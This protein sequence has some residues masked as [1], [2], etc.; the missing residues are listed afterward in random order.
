MTLVNM[1]ASRD[2]RGSLTVKRDGIG[3]TAKVAF[4]GRLLQ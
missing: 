4:P 1:L 2:L 3:V